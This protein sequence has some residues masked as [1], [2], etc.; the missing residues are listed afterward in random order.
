M[1]D[2]VIKLDKLS[3][4]LKK[5]SVKINK[6]SKKV[7][8]GLEDDLIKVGNLIRNKIVLSMTNTPKGVG[9][10][11]KPGKPPAVD[12]GNLRNNIIFD[13]GRNFVEIGASTRAEYAPILE[14]GSKFMKPRPWLEENT[15]EE[16]PK[17]VNIV[18]DRFNKEKI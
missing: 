10:R 3:P 18:I 12:T 16:L 11:S 14:I 8:K 13:S 1:A 4:E 2:K 6:Y 5:L 17:I 15:K 7:K 9:G